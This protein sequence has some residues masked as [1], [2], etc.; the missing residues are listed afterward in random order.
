MA[1]I[2]TMCWGRYGG[3]GLGILG[4]DGG[5]VVGREVLGVGSIP[6]AILPSCE[7]MKI[8]H[9]NCININIVW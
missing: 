4:G 5:L 6:I 3:A 8:L 2:S 7:D 1:S 9:Y